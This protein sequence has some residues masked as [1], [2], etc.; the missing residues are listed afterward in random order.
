MMTMFLCML[1]WT[2]EID[3]KFANHEGG[4]FKWE[5]TTH[6]NITF[7]HCTWQHELLAIHYIFAD[8]YAAFQNKLDAN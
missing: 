8:D 6:E 4:Y 2:A 7:G 5:N 3:I 1:I